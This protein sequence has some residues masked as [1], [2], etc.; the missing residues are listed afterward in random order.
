MP[1]PFPPIQVSSKKSLSLKELSEEPDSVSLVRVRA[2]L[3]EERP[4]DL[5]L[6]VER[7]CLIPLVGLTLSGVR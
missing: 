4:P 3:G 7:A 5:M 2:A 6:W 1:N